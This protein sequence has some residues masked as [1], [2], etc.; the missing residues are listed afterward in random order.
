M[1]EPAADGDRRVTLP[2]PERPYD[3]RVTF[4]A[5]SWGPGDPL[6]RLDPERAIAWRATRTPDGPA[7]Y[8]ACLLPDAV[9]VDAWGEG[10]D[11]V[12]ARASALVGLD[13]DGAG[14]LTDHPAL[15]DLA[16]RYAG[17]HLPRSGTVFEH[18]VPA[19]IHQLV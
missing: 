3:L 17:A 10:A 18:V 7:S 12:A 16:R 2:R 5:P 13:D 8:R 4:R 9:V 14:Y 6:T 11:W 1:T 15:R 19:V